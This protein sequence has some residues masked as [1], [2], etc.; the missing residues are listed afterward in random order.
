MLAN[1]V[2]NVLMSNTIKIRLILFQYNK[3]FSCNSIAD[4]ILFII[5]CD[6]KLENNAFFKMKSVY[7]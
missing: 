3:T 7:L 1:T 4:S 2:E 6:Y 5:L